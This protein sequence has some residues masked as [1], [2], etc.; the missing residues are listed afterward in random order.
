M[1]RNGSG[2]STLLWALQGT[3]TRAR[4]GTVRGRR[5][6]PAACRAEG[7]RRLVGLVPQTAADLLYLETVDE[8]CAAADR[9]PGPGR[10]GAPAARP[11]RARHRPDR[12]PA[13]PLRGAAAG[14]GARRRA[15]R[16][17]AGDLPRRADARAR[18]PRQ[19]RARRDPRRADRGG[20]C[21]ARGTHDVEFVA[22]V[23][24]RVVV[25]AEGEV[26]SEGPTARVVAESPAFA[27]QV[28]KILGAGWLTVDQVAARPPDE[29]PRT[30]SRRRRRHRG[31]SRSGLRS[32]A[33]L[34]VASLA[35]L[36]MFLWPLLVTVRVD[37][38]RAAAVRLPA[39]AARGDHGVPRR[40]H[41][42]RDGLQGAGDAR[43]AHRINAVMRGLS[44]RGWP[45]SSW[46]SSC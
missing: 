13:R 18:L 14:P 11:A 5:R 38:R 40:V 2:K 45:A 33:V 12:A 30:P 27:P 17:A 21:R 41:R 42:G 22:Q 44:A 7:R 31:R 6:G 26:V 1:G 9:E 15:H 43:R 19:G 46:C 36:L 35:G 32:A 16:R 23:A 3:A 20:S 8:E 10:H 4:S 34:A 25:L 28:H 29:R 37:G 39:A 24:D